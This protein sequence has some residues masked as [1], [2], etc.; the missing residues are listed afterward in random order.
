MQ[1][2]YADEL[3]LKLLNF[4]MFHLRMCIGL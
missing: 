2:N 3:S 4:I 1:N